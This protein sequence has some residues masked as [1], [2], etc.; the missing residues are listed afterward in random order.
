MVTRAPKSK[1]KKAAKPLAKS[2]STK[3]K[4]AKMAKKVKK[5]P[6]KKA[7]PVKSA[8][9]AKKAEVK[10]PLKKELTAADVKQILDARELVERQ[11]HILAELEARGVKSIHRIPKKADKDLVDEAK[12]LEVQVPKVTEK[13]KKAGLGS[14]Y[15]MLKNAEKALVAPKPATVAAST[16][17]SSTSTSE[18]KQPK[19]VIIDGEEV[20]LVEEDDLDLNLD[21][22]E[23][24]K[25]EY[26][27]VSILLNLIKKFVHLYL[28]D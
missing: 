21:N 6:A 12:A 20:E 2:A 27:V 9:P 14:P 18:P 16:S 1:A 5:A 8:K 25:E 7:N 28:T 4:M 15:R 22:I 13:L 3:A 19:T 11:K 24:V 26:F 23:E 17:S 10:V